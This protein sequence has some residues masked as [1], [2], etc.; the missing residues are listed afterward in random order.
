MRRG[1]DFYTA[2]AF[3]SMTESRD[4]KTRQ[5]VYSVNVASLKCS[6]DDSDIMMKPV[7]NGAFEVAVAGAA[8]AAPSGGVLE[9]SPEDSEPPHAARPHTAPTRTAALKPRRLKNLP[10][11][12]WRVHALN[13]YLG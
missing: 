1:G 8:G 4:A 5:S 3:L 6:C 11:Y 7:P 2:L 12:G 9:V 10:S 13:A